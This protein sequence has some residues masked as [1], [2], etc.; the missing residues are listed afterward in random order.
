[1]KGSAIKGAVRA[2]LIIGVLC[3]IPFLIAR[4]IAEMTGDRR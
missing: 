1:M 2:L 4:A 3:A